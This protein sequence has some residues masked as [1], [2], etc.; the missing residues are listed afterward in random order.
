MSFGARDFETEKPHTILVVREKN[1]GWTREVWRGRVAICL[2]H[3]ANISQQRVAWNGLDKDIYWTYD[4]V[5]NYWQ[6]IGIPEFVDDF[7]LKNFM[8]EYEKQEIIKISQLI[9]NFDKIVELKNMSNDEI[10]K[11]RSWLDIS[12]KS[13]KLYLSNFQSDDEEYSKT[14]SLENYHK[15]LLVKEKYPLK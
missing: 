5:L 9:D 10:W 7:F 14:F 2:F 6:D 1:M 12:E 11:S 8:N 15:T 13:K 4:E 3:L